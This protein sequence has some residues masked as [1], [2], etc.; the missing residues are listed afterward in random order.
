MTPRD[1]AFRVVVAGAGPVG[2]LFALRLMRQTAQGAVSVRVVDAG[3][4]ARW[5]RGAPTDLRV[6]AL[7]RES[8]YLFGGQWDA[9][10]RTRVSPY[11]AMRVFE[12]DEPFGRRSIGFDAADIGEPDLGHIVEDSLIRSVLLDGLTAA[13]V[14]TSFGISVREIATGDG[15]VRVTTTADE[16]FVADLV[17]GA[18]GGESVVRQAAGIDVFERDYGQHAIVAN[19]ETERPHAQT[20]WQRFLPDGPLA[21]LPLADGRSSIVWSQSEAE[22]RRRLALGDAE[23]LGEL[24][25][26]SANVLG[27]ITGTTARRAFP[28]RLRHA[29]GYTRP[30]IA[31]IGDAAHTVHPLAGQGMNLGLRDAAVLVETLR[32]AL[33]AGEYPADEFVL[34]RYARAQ[35]AHNL[36]MQLAFDAINTLFGAELPTWLQPLRGLG[37]GVIDRTGPAKRLLIRRAL[38]LDRA[39][40]REYGWV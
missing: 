19:V 39:D 3:A 11:G 18:D 21:F 26:A 10:L 32:R 2:L 6:Y 31:L 28:L 30:G 27:A 4:P 20:A 33:A 8:Q 16:E 37:L 23:F 17:V 5:T 14:E 1:R 34:R 15:G 22:A 9:M 13:G 38:G 40:A 12:G 36:G 29:L 24:H 35:K 25:A 7:S